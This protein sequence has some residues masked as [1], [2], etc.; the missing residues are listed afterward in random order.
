MGKGGQFSN[1][2]TNGLYAD[3]TTLPHP[4]SRAIRD[5]QSRPVARSKGMRIYALPH[6]VILRG[7]AA[8]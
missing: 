4:I 3:V 1:P 6:V 5:L 2:L 7:Q 8:L